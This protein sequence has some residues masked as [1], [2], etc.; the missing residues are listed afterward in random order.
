[1]TLRTALL[2]VSLIIIGII[3]LICHLKYHQHNPKKRLVGSAA[4][5]DEHTLLDEDANAPFI[6]ENLIPDIPPG[7]ESLLEPQGPQNT[8][9]L[10]TPEL[11]TSQEELDDRRKTARIIADEFLPK[12][13]DD[14][15]IFEHHAILPNIKKPVAEIRKI[16][17]LQPGRIKENTDLMATIKKQSRFSPIEKIK[18]R[19][20]VTHLKTVFRLKQ[21]SGFADETAIGEYETFVNTLSRRL[22][23]E[24]LF[25]LKTDQAIAASQK[26]KAFVSEND[27]I[28]ILYILSKPDATFNGTDLQSALTSAGLEFGEFKFFH[29]SPSDGENANQKLFSVASMYKP[30]CFDPDAMEKF[31]TMGLCAYM[32]PALI[33]DPIGGFTEMCTRC[34]QI[35]DDLSGVLTTNQRELLNED[36]FRLIRDRII[37]HKNRLNE[38]GIDNGSDIAQMIFS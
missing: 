13:A 7:T 22:D 16:F 2:L 1:M 25:A 14:E 34:H 35:A 29:F 26:L 11:T 24:R 8:E 38:S 31:S 30:G 37:E 18:A 9:A 4:V 21:R 3:G 27:L 28:I 5:P 15:F 33:N 10:D 6:N 23:C 19:H 36:N 20:H 32:V 17:E 12:F